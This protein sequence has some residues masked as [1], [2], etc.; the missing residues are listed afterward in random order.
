MAAAEAGDSACSTAA[1]P[2]VETL[3]LIPAATA[4]TCS[5]YCREVA[6]RALLE[7]L[8]GKPD[9]LHRPLYAVV[10]F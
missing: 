2:I 8:R 6:I 7:R 9:S 3:Q 5:M 10:Q 1:V 4:Q